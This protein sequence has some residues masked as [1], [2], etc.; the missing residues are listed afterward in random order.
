MSP[1]SDGIGRAEALQASPRGFSTGYY[2][3]CYCCGIVSEG[4]KGRRIRRRAG[5]NGRRCADDNGV[6]MGRR[7]GES[8]Y[9]E[10]RRIRRRADDNGTETGRKRLRKEAKGSLPICGSDPFEQKHRN[11]GVKIRCSLS[12]QTTVVFLI[13]PLDDKRGVYF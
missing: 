2:P 13:D 9:G 8:R 1:G 10:E 4:E 3:F 5:K 7:Y 6:E 12:I 11:L